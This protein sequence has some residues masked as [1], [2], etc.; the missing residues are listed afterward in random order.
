MIAILFKINFM[1]PVPDAV[2]VQVCHLS[3]SVA[4]PVITDLNLK[5]ISRI[6]AVSSPANLIAIRAQM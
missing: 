5:A 2:A 1:Y 3:G 4:A 6:S